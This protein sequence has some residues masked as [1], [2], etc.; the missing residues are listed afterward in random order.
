MWL[1]RRIELHPRPRGVHLVTREVLAALPELAQVQTGLLHLL[2]QHTSA[3]LALNEDAS[4]EVRRDLESWLNAAVPEQ[5]RLWTH[6]LEGAD[7]MPAHVKAV[8]IG[9]SLT[10]PLEEGQLALGT[11]QGLYLCEHRNAGG[12]RVLVATAWGEE[13]P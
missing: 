9:P 2:I 5:A 13:R 4:P 10:L 1:Q 7:D 12:P 6:T 3:S 8:L 11:W